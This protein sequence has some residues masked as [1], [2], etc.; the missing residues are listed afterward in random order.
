L[1]QTFLKT[2]RP[3]EVQYDE[4][5]TRIWVCKLIT[6]FT[7]RKTLCYNPFIA[8]IKQFLLFIRFDC[9][10]NSALGNLWRNHLVGQF[11]ANQAIKKIICCFC[12]KL[13]P[14]Q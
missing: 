10:G 1:A 5:F 12:Q 2:I 4:Q 8:I 11:T 13:T 7:F 6:F 14:S 3:S 9:T